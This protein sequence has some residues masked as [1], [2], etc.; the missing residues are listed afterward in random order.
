[1]IL[2]LSHYPLDLSMC[3]LVSHTQIVEEGFAA[4]HYKKQHFGIHTKA[5]DNI[6][7]E[8][9][10]KTEKKKEIQLNRE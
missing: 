5:A 3:I 1:M 9:I 7:N 8:K 10:S 4:A 6:R 2:N